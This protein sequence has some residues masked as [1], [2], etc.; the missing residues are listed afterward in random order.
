MGSY[1]TS[2][3]W[4]HYNKPRLQTRGQSSG[5]LHPRRSL[6]LHIRQTFHPFESSTA[7]LSKMRPGDILTTNNP[8]LASSNDKH[9][10]TQ[11]P[12]TS[13]S[14]TDTLSLSIGLLQS[15]ICACT[16][17]P[18]PIDFSSNTSTQAKP[19]PPLHA[20]INPKKP[21]KPP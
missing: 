19:H 10:K 9:I 21:N 13:I 7:N 2:Y 14:S 17:A 6:P 4:K 12:R 16:Y 15:R 11:A 8:P 18:P 5:A 3:N 1:T 20:W